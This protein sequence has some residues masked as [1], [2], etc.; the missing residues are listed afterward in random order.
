MGFPYA[1]SRVHSEC[2]RYLA[3]ML[4]I[5]L[6]RDIARMFSVVIQRTRERAKSQKYPSANESVLKVLY[7][8][9]QVNCLTGY[10]VQVFPGSAGGRGGSDRTT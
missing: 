6:F 5:G 3:L 9:W 1:G 10:D 2:S 4:D 8:I 7:A